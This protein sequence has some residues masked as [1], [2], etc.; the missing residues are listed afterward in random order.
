VAF[1]I[2]LDGAYSV[3]Y[4]FRGPKAGDA[5]G[6]APYLIQARNGNFY[7]TS[8]SGGAFGGDLAGVVFELTPAG[9]ERVLYSFGPLDFNPSSPNAGVIEMGDAIFNGITAYA[10]GGVGGGTVFKLTLNR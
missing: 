7:G 2:T 10:D 8:Y 4:A 3:L 6:P 5:S 9:S 1:R